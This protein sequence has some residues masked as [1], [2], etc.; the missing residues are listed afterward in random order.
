MKKRIKNKQAKPKG[1]VYKGQYIEK[2]SVYSRPK[3]KFRT[4]LLYSFY[5]H[6]LFFK[7]IGKAKRFIDANANEY[8]KLKI[9]EEANN[10]CEPY[11]EL[12]NDGYPMLF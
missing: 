10:F 4:I 9:Q 8:H 5:G 12:E 3:D 2:N 6:E 7:S 11:P 1:V